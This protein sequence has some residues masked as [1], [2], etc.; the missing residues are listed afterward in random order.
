MFSDRQCPSIHSVD[1]GGVEPKL[2]AGNQKRADQRQPIRDSNSSHK[3][4]GQREFPVVKLCSSV[5]RVCHDN[6][7][8]PCR[9]YRWSDSLLELDWI[10]LR[11][12]YPD[13]NCEPDPRPT[14]IV[15]ACIRGSIRFL[16]I[17]FKPSEVMSLCLPGFWYFSLYQQSR[18]WSIYSVDHP[19]DI[20]PKHG[21]KSEVRHFSSETK[22]TSSAKEY[23]QFVPKLD[24]TKGPTSRR[25]KAGLAHKTTSD[26]RTTSICTA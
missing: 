16:S 19:R 6:L 26:S 11:Q 20:Q 25:D 5:F 13:Q 21:H 17:W 10:T 8:L 1:L 18:T 24:R 22:V 15:K 14:C 12:G 9:R 2:H 4:Q 23:V 3:N 7:Q